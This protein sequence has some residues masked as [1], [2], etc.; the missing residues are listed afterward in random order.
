MARESVIDP[1]ATVTSFMTA[2]SVEVSVD[3]YQEY[4]AP[5]EM[6]RTAQTE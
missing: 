5:A 6:P 1:P 2:N 4:V 3:I